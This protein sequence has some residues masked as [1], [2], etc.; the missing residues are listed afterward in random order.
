MEPISAPVAG[1]N[2]PPMRNVIQVY[3]SGLPVVTYVQLI[4]T[5]TGMGYTLRL[6]SKEAKAWQEAEDERLKREKARIDAA[7]TQS[8]V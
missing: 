8:K 4:V 1:P 5:T 7:I 6:A 3:P 2:P